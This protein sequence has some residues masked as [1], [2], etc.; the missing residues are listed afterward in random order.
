MVGNKQPGSRKTLPH[1]SFYDEIV[2]QQSC[3]IVPCFQYPTSLLST[4]AGR[5]SVHSFS[6]SLHNLLNTT[7]NQTNPLPL[8]PRVQP[9]SAHASVP[10]AMP[11]PP[12]AYALPAS[13]VARLP[14]HLAARYS[15]AM[16]VLGQPPSPHLPPGY[17]PAGMPPGYVPPGMPL[18]PPGGFP[19]NPYMAAFPFNPYM[20]RPPPGFGPPPPPPPAGRVGGPPV[21]F[22]Y[23]A[24]AK[25]PTIE[26]DLEKIRKSSCPDD[27]PICM[28][29]LLSEKT[30]KL[31]C[32]HEFHRECTSEMLKRATTCAVCRRPASKSGLPSNGL[33][34]SGSLTILKQPA[35]QGQGC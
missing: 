27:C 32:G 17:V 21:S 6:V 18:A 3:Q 30:Y 8:P 10:R 25:L 16:A 33:Q 23:A 5:D 14:P 29:P 24:P 1:A 34:P 31:P 20:G 12:G 35:R 4:Q 26:E 15:A 9:L 28:M 2:L 19:F 22:S 11:P 13:V 7:F